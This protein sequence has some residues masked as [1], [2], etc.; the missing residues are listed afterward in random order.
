[1]AVVDASVLIKA[2]VEELGSTRAAHVLGTVDPLHAPG[3]ALA[4]VAEVLLRKSRRGEFDGRRIG[5]AIFAVMNRTETVDLL[6]IIVDAVQIA[7][8]IECSVYDALYLATARSLDTVVITCDQRLMRKAA[9]SP[10][11]R[12]VAPLEAWGHGP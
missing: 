8:A 10:Y 6:D 11:E 2:F 1:M 4:E 5:E 12:F 7:E 9:G 3:H